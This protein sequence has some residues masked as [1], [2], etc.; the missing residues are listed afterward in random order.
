[1]SVSHQVSFFDTFVNLTNLAEN[2][3]TR[4]FKLVSK[5]INL[6][7]FITPDLY[8]A[9]YKHF[10]R[11]HKFSLL[12]FLNALLVKTL[13]KIPTVKALVAFINA[14]PECAAFC[15]LT[16]APDETKFSWFM[17]RFHKHIKALFDNM[18]QHILPLCQDINSKRANTLIF[19]T[20]GVLANVRENSP[21]FVNAEIKKAKKLKKSNPD[22][23]PYSY[24]Y[25][26]M[27]KAAAAK[28]CPV[29]LS[30]VNG[31][32]AYA[33][34]FGIIT[35]A[36]GIPLDILPLNN[37]AASNDPL[38]DKDLSDFA[39]LKPAV[40]GFLN[41]HPGFVRYTFI[42]DSAFDNIA[43]YDFLL[44]DCGFQR[45]VIPF[46]PR[47]AK[48]DNASDFDSNGTPFCKV[49]N[50]P[51]K[52]IGSTKGSNRAPRLKFLCPLS[53][54]DGNTRRSYSAC[55]NPCSDS[56]CRARYVASASNRRLY[57][58]DVPRDTDHWNN[59]YK[60][61]PAIEQAIYSLKSF[62]SAFC[63]SSR[64]SNTVFSNLLFGAIAS[65]SILILARKLSTKSFKSFNQVLKA[66]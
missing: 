58:G 35:N 36:L 7:S 63:S 14:S 6:S 55:N 2:N 4:L 52:F 23:N 20:T 47:A 38:S 62:S 28:D 29:S 66:A 33:H 8:R 17:T 25:S 30:C 21:K 27:P 16:V 61:R 51:F 60:Q 31:S 48:F 3:V 39:A 32:F 46:N 1:M 64:N 56:N 45:A 42:G 44:G 19:D 57:P 54:R 40:S 50:R 43:S 65:L 59:I 18:V 12:S 24:V 41:R 15:N 10:G 22:F 5:N 9:F 26:H 34:R 11:K 13:F 49:S 53:F 37:P